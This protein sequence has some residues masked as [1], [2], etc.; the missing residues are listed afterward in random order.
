[1]SNFVT[2]SE[3][4]ISTSRKCFIATMCLSRTVCPKFTT[5]TDKRQ[6]DN[7]TLTIGLPTH[8]FL[9]M[10]RQKLFDNKQSA[11]LRLPTRKVLGKFQLQPT[12]VR[13]TSQ[14]T[15]FKICA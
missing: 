10:S 11:D 12:T 2:D 15:V 9:A 14:L 4:L 5:V 3:R 13:V 1:M 7:Y 6:T 8:G